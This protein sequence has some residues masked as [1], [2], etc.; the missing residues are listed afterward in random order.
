MKKI[1]FLTPFF[2]F[3]PKDGWRIRVFNLIKHLSRHYEITVLSFIKRK[4]KKYINDLSLYCDV[5]TVDKQ[6]SI[7]DMTKKC[8]MTH[9]DCIIVINKVR[10]TRSMKLSPGWDIINL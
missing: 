5:F 1:L 7:L 4:E 3:P 2:P 9:L 6:D 10:L 8:R